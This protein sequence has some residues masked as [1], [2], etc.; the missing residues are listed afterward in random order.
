MKRHQQA[1]SGIV[2]IFVTMLLIIIMS[3]LVL[4]FAQL[5]RRD[6]R[7]SLDN[8][9]S[10]Q[11][12]Y[13]AETGVNDA[14]TAVAAFLNNPA[15]AGKDLPARQQCGDN[16]V[17]NLND[18]QTISS[19][20][21]VGYSC[22]LIDPTPNYLT[23]SVGGTAAS[24]V[25]V[26]TT[27]GGNVGSLVLQWTGTSNGV[28]LPPNGMAGCPASGNFVTAAS[29]AEYAN[30]PFGG[31]RIDLVPVQNASD[32][33]RNSLISD[34]MVIFAMPRK[35]NIGG[36]VSYITG[37]GTTQ[38][39]VVDAINCNSGSC[40]I[41]I[42]GL[43]ENSYYM[44]LS[45]LY[46]DSNLTITSPGNSFKDSQATV[47]STGKAQDVL[48]RILVSVPLQSGEGTLP[49]AALI[50]GDS[51][52]KRFQVSTDYFAVDGATIDGGDGNPLCDP[53]SGGGGGG[54]GGA[55]PDGDAKFSN[56]DPNG[57]GGTGN[58]GKTNSGG[59][60]WLRTFYNTSDNADA[61]VLSCSW[62]WG[63]GS[64]NSTTACYNGNSI[65]H[66]FPK[67]VTTCTKYTV[68]LTVNLTNGK[69]PKYTSIDKE[70]HGSASGC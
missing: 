17:Y 24:I 18:T 31:L 54:G 26:K 67:S 47:D 40:Q 45:R 14:K 30:C 8:Q 5:S 22:V 53:G 3:L 43:T 33:K 51:V 38:G 39:K 32:L 57:G 7:E 29:P 20:N 68:V 25:P 16:S 69:S 1:E 10:N 13:A 11:A 65:Q 36:T 50:S 23:A 49:G 55:G 4:A 9:L 34:D 21:K 64:A 62:N 42:G 66:T 6:Q 63:D 35:T 28:S 2:S 37:G 48:R 19:A 56:N 52:C 70:P 61:D 15:N 12:F 44:R 59:P 46:L 58:T 41:T 60:Y 27:S